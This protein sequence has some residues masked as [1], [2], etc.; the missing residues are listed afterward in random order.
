MST[1]L[2]ILAVLIALAGG[3]YLF[4]ELEAVRVGAVSALAYLVHILIV[5]S[6][7][8]VSWV[9]A[10]RIDRKNARDNDIAG[11]F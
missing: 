1:A 5:A 11:T 9:V 7:A 8:V 2:K 10:R 4:V 3:F 6:L